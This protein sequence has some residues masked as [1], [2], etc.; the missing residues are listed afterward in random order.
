MEAFRLD[1]C[2]TNEKLCPFQQRMMSGFPKPECFPQCV[3]KDPTVASQSPGKSTYDERQEADKRAAKQN[4]CTP[5][6]RLT[7]SGGTLGEFSFRF[8]SSLLPGQHDE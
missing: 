1:V 4:D 8:K 3:G 6:L 2:G 5:D 7:R